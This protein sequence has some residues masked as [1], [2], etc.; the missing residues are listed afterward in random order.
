MKTSGN[1]SEF[2]I[3]ASTGVLSFEMRRHLSNFTDVWE[4]FATSIFSIEPEDGRS[5]FL[6]NVR[7]LLPEYMTSHPRSDYQH[8]RQYGW[9][10]ADVSEQEWGVAP[11]GM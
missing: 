9:T 8:E 4:E 10:V 5:T 3:T 2:P 6:R 11:G 1:E 7:K